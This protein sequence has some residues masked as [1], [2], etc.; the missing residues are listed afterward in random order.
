MMRA[1][2]DEAS[3]ARD[4]EAEILGALE[5]PTRTRIARIQQFADAIRSA[6]RN[7]RRQTDDLTQTELAKRLGVSVSTISRLESGRGIAGIDFEVALSALAEL[8]A[9]PTLTLLD[10]DAPE[11]YAVVDRTR[12]GHAPQQAAEEPRWAEAATLSAEGETQPSAESSGSGSRDA[13]V[14][15]LAVSAGVQSELEAVREEM[16]RLTKAVEHLSQT[17]RGRSTG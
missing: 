15:E 1:K 9:A 3:T 6:I 7:R 4:A 17:G 8:G 11:A 16:A 12:T 5:E 13:P 10:A 14:S 2:R